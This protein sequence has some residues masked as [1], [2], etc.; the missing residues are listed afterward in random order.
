MGTGKNSASYQTTNKCSLALESKDEDMEEPTRGMM[1]PKVIRDLLLDTLRGPS[2]FP[3]FVPPDQDLGQAGHLLHGGPLV[4]LAMGPVGSSACHSAALV[5]GVEEVD[6][7]P[8]QAV[9]L[10]LLAVGALLGV[11]LTSFPAVTSRALRL[12]L[13][14][15]LNGEYHNR[16]DQADH[17]DTWSL[18]ISFKAHDGAWKTPESEKVEGAVRVGRE[19]ELSKAKDKHLGGVLGEVSWSLEDSGQS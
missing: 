6:F 5:V 18:A 14:R 7:L 8:V 1:S 13:G 3:G 12:L 2:H 4:P 9:L 17:D 11:L 15:V 19:G 10:R 16:N